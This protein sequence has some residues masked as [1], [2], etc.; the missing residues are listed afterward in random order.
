MVNKINFEKNV[1]IHQIDYKENLAVAMKMME[2]IA[3]DTEDDSEIN[4]E[5]KKVD[6]MEQDVLHMIEFHVFNASEG[7]NL[8][9][10]LQEIRQERRSIKNRFEEKRKARHFIRNTY[11]QLK[12]PLNQTLTTFE[13]LNNHQEGRKYTLRALPQLEG[14]NKLINNAKIAK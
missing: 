1:K 12:N 13:G 10:M 9:K 2:E 7:Y 14:F 3:M 11:K 6:L 8:A 4:E 5:L